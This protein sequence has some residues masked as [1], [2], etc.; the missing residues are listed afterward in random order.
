MQW[1]QG[2]QSL[3]A[4]QERSKLAAQ[5]LLHSSLDTVLFIFLMLHIIKVMVVTRKHRPLHPQLLPPGWQVS[6]QI[7]V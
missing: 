5:T 3:L 6:S 7:N 4:Y 2:M 1:M